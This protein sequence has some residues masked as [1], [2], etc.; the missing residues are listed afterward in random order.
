MND[1]GRGFQLRACMREK[2]YDRFSNRFR[3]KSV[4]FFHTFTLNYA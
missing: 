2:T 3:E 4:S 1:T